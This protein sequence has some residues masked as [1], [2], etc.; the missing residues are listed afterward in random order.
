MNINKIIKEY[1][2]IA[3]IALSFAI[4]ITNFNACFFDAGKFIVEID[5]AFGIVFF[6]VF[7]ILGISIRDYWSKKTKIRALVLIMS[8]NIIIAFEAFFIAICSTLDLTLKFIATI[9]F[10]IS[11]L[12]MF[13]LQYIEQKILQKE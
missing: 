4:I 8:A 12:L 1:I 13:L 6:A 10:V 2:I 11:F 5:V 3:C 9:I 7:M